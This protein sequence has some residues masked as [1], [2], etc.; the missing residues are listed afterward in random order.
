M[1]KK[2]AIVFL[3]CPIL[4]LVSC[5]ESE[6]Q[7]PLLAYIDQVNQV[8]QNENLFVDGFYEIFKESKKG[9]LDSYNKNEFANIITIS[10]DLEFYGRNSMKKQ[11]DSMGIVKEL[12]RKELQTYHGT[13]T[14][15][16]DNRSETTTFAYKNGTVNLDICIQK[17]DTSNCTYLYEKKQYGGYFATYEFTIGIYDYIVKLLNKD[18]MMIENAILDESKKQK[19]IFVF[20]NEDTAFEQK[21]QCFSI[22]FDENDKIMDIVYICNTVYTDICNGNKAYEYNSFSMS[23]LGK[24]P[25]ITVSSVYEEELSELN[26]L[27]L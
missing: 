19:G 3:I 2:I 8:Y 14:D 5:E 16:Y 27:Y 12:D 22:Y 4:F 15:V 7:S 11:Y 25:E 10:A 23:S 17:E 9:C 13:N 26:R 6:Q 18:K 1:I 24:K 21:Q 20:I